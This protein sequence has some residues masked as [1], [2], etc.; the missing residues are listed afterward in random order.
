MISLTISVTLFSLLDEVSNSNTFPPA[1]KGNRQ[2]T[3]TVNEGVCVCV[4]AK[5]IALTVVVFSVFSGLLVVVM[6]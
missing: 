6:G 5:L 4:F 1:K 3:T 2:S